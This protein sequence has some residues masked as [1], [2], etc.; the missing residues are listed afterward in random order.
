[1]GLTVAISSIL[2]IAPA[3]F[4]Q[5]LDSY[6]SDKADTAVRVQVVPPPEAL[7]QG[8][9]LLSRLQLYLGIRKLRAIRPPIGTTFIVQSSAYAPSPYQ[10]D[11]TPC[12]TAAGTRV[13]PG[14]VASNFLPI[15][16]L[17]EINGEEYIVED[18]MSPRFQGYFLDVWF[19]STS[20]ALA[21]GRQ[22]LAITIV[23]YGEPGQSIRQAG[24][25]AETETVDTPDVSVWVAFRSRLAYFGSLLGARLATDVDRFDVDCLKE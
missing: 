5:S 3:V 23:G 25:E 8:R 2:V 17:L 22:K 4:A 6:L 11:S 18:R 24:A 19:P 1:M 9:S 7:R 12:I 13:R 21:F 16:T 10:T 15:G 14:V 20:S